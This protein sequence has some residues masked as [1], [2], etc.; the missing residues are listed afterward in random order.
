MSIKGSFERAQ[1]SFKWRIIDRYFSFFARSKLKNKTFSIISNNCIS[2]GIYHKFGLPFSTPTVWCFFFPEEYIR[3][4]ENL[5]WY[6]N[7]PLQFTPQTKHHSAQQLRQPI[8][9]NYPIGVL[10]GDVEIHFLH[11][12]DEAYALDKWNRRLA[13]VNWERLFFLFSDSEPQEFTRTLLERY[14][15]LPFEHKLFFS[16]KPQPN[17]ECTVYVKD[18]M[19]SASV[20]D[21]TRN[22]K[23]EKYVDLVKWFNGE[24]DF[25]KK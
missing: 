16:S 5:K 9:R 4:L 11:Y 6:L 14:E 12:H 2:G 15:K 19:G 1:T 10:G 25:L 3:F 22:R 8:Q 17:S 13:R 23:Y 24:T 21:S 7:Q 20:S 18:C